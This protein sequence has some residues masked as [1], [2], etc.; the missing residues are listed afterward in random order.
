MNKTTEEHYEEKRLFSWKQLKV[1]PRGY[2]DV[3]TVVDEVSTKEN[4]NHRQH[5]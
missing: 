1:C 2:N 5:K 4:E 3:F